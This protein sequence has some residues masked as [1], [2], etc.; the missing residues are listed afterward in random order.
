MAYIGTIGQRVKVRCT[1]RKSFE[2]VDHKYSY[3]GTVHYIHTFDDEEGNVLVWKS[4]NPVETI[5]DGEGNPNR[6]GDT[7][8]I[9][10]GSMVELTG[11]VKSHETYKGTV[12]Q[13][14]FT[15]CKFSL[16]QRAMTQEEKNAK[17]REEQLASIGQNDFIWEM[18]Y[19]QYKDHYSDC[20]TIADSY[21]PHENSRGVRYGVPTIAVII[22]EGRLKPSGTR[23]EH[24]AG[25][26]LQNEIGE[27][28]TY[29]A[30]KEENAIQRAN[31]DFPGHCW[32]CVKV[33]SHDRPAYLW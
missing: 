30:I 4:T 17:R 31:K 10:T 13:T 24:Y 29:R 19:R 21:N 5:N 25:F 15:R 18:P 11:T 6:K 9:P 14:I 1:Y 20:E 12:E 22:R 27:H 23:G 2:Y 8:F 32:Q 7:V 26:V 16:I 3:Y 33:Y 28:I